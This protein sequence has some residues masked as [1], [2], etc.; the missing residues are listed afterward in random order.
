MNCLKCDKHR[1][2]LSRNVRSHTYRAGLAANRTQ[3]GGDVPLAITTNAH[4]QTRND[5]TVRCF[6]DS[7]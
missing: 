6:N 5:H 4:R 2:L 1:I 3:H 7:V